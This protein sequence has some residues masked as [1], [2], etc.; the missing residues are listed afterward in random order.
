VELTTQFEGRE[1]H[2]LAYGFDPQHPELATTL[3]SLRQVRGLEVHSI[4]TS[5]PYR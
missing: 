3:T 5:R 2:L 1:A 4:A